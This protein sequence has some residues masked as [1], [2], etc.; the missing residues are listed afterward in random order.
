MATLTVTTSDGDELSF[1]VSDAKTTIGR[2]PSNRIVIPDSS[3]STRH[4]EITN[5]NGA[6]A[7][8]DSGSTN[9]IKVNGAKVDS[10]PLNDGDHLMLGHVSGNFTI[11]PAG[12]K[13]MPEE[14]SIE[15]AATSA[16]PSAAFGKKVKEKDS[17]A[18]ALL[19]LGIVAILVA[20]A[21]I[22]CSMI[23]TA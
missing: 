19:S 9:G 22:A 11:S 17:K 3:L 7:I 1:D 20:V 23:M 21:G 14:T 13:P 15:S 8:S 18:Q 2:G 12:S 16:R 5:E 6:F 4:A 10:S